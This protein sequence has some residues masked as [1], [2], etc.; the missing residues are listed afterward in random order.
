M[1]LFVKSEG[2]KK[3]NVGCALDEGIANPDEGFQLFYG[4]RSI[5]RKYFELSLYAVLNK[6]TLS[7]NFNLKWTVSLL[8][9]LQMTWLSPEA[10]R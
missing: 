4:E 1:K 9:G 7:F 3:L 10:K 5:W 2:F 8:F 6:L